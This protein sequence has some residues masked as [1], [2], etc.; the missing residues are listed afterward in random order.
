MKNLYKTYSDEEKEI[1]NNLFINQVDSSRKNFE[2]YANEYFKTLPG[3]K[4]PIM[5]TIREQDFSGNLHKITIV[6]NPE[7][8]SYNTHHMLWD[9][10]LKDNLITKFLS[11]SGFKVT[12]SNLYT[13]NVLHPNWNH[14]NKDGVNALMLLAI[15][16]NLELLTQVAN[17]FN[18]DLDKKD[19]NHKYFT[20]F[21]FSEIEIELEPLN[22][23]FLS[24]V[25]GHFNYVEKL[26]DENPHHFKISHVRLGRII[27]EWEKTMQKLNDDFSNDE[28]VNFYAAVHFK[29]EQHGSRIL[30][31]ILN[32]KLE[33]TLSVK[34]DSIRKSASVKI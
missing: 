6:N 5:H 30:T 14:Q 23:N 17:D 19:K 27:N 12:N 22:S 11:D 4:K 2:I 9:E 18:L 7:K 34:N 16:K 31:K 8:I 25:Q 1:F 13:L 10:K 21:L 15:R 3:T 26:I 29:I 24:R 33:I 20:H 28:N 32:Y